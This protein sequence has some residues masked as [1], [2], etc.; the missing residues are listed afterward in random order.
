M[1]MIVNHVKNMSLYV[2]FHLLWCA[3]NPQEDVE[4]EKLGGLAVLQL[5]D[6]P[7]CKCNHRKSLG[8][9]GSPG[10]FQVISNSVTRKT[11]SS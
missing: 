1:S 6:K 5:L 2:L 7:G 4:E 3:E 11:S 9:H 10:P 8:K